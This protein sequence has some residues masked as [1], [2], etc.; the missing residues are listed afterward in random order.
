MKLKIVSVGNSAG[1]ILPKDVLDHLKLEKGDTLYLRETQN[2]YEVSPYDPDFDEYM[3]AA[4]IIM[5]ENRDALHRL[6]GHDD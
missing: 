2:G 1:V 6:A 3:E 4:R 5:R